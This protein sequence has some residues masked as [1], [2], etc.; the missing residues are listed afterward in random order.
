MEKTKQATK[1]KRS[2][3]SKLLRIFAWLVASVFFLAILILI[4]IQ[5]PAVQNFGRKKVVA[6]LEHKL[7]TKVEIGKL[8]INFPT[9]L[10]LQNVYFEDQSKDTLLYGGEIKVNLKMLRL[11][12]NDIEIEEISLNNILAKIKRLPPDSVFNF[13]FIA[14]AFAGDQKKETKMKDTAAL[15]MN[16]D[17]LLVNHTRIIYKDAFTGNDMDL[18]FGHL[19]TRI[20]TFDPAHLLFNFPFI[21]LKGLKGHFYQLAPLQKPIENAIAEASAQPD[22]Y[23]QL[24]NKE[25]KLSDVDVIYKSE[26]THL[27][28]SFVI[29][30]LIL[31]PKTIDLKNSIITL[32]D[33]T[34]T[35]SD[36][37]IEMASQKKFLQTKK[38]M[39]KD[40][41]LTV[42]PTPPF[43]IIAEEITI[44][45]SRLRYDDPSVPHTP[46]GMDY[47]HLDLQELSLNAINLQ[48]SM[49]TILASVKSASLKEKSG[50]VLNN[51]STDFA[52]NPTGVSLQNLLIET[53]G[54]EIKNAASITYP[55]LEAIVKDPGLIGLDIDLQN[56]KIT[57]KDLLTFVPQM[58][59]QSSSLSPHSTLYIN[60]RIT[61]KVNDM[62]FQRLI[63]RG[64]SATD[65]NATG[66]IK[67]L[68]DP[69]RLY[70]DV[71]IQKFQTSKKD[72][73]SFLP[74]NMVPPNITLPES[75]ATSGK[76]KGG[77]NKLY[78]DLV[79]T[80]SLG[81]AKIKGT[82]INITDQN[83]A[84]YDLVVHAG[85]LQLGTIMQNPKL[86]FL[87]GDIKVKGSGFKPETANATFSGVIAN[88]TLNN[89][90]YRNIKAGGSIA[91]KIYKIDASV[92]DPNLDA[93]IAANGE[94]A[95]KFPGVHL[96]ATIDSI[97]TLP[98][99]LTASEIKYHGQIEGDFTNTDPDNLAGNLLVTHSVLVNNGKRIALDSLE[100]TAANMDGGHSLTLQSDLLSATIK[101]QY[102]LTQLADVF[103]Q[104]IDPYFSLSNKINSTKI[105]PYHF[106]IN[107]GTFDNAALKAFLPELKQLKPVSLTGNFASDSGWNVSIKSPY[108]LYGSYT[109][110]AAN[111]T[112]GTHKGILSY[113]TSFKQFKSGTSLSVYATSLEGT[114]Q[115]NNL[116]FT[117]H[118]KDQKSVTK[119]SLSGLLSQPKTGNYQFSLLPDNLLL[120]YDK[121]S[122]NTDNA[123]QYF[124]KDIAAHNFIL[125]EGTQQLSLNSTSSGHNS[126]L[127]IDFKNFKIATLSS[128]V[129][130][131]SLMVN[132]LL[133]G[134]AVVKNIQTQPTFTTDLTV[135]D[136]SIYKDT[137]GTLT[138]KV[139]NELANTYHAAISLAGRGNEVNVNGDYL[140]T[141]TNSSYDFVLDVGKF[142]MK[143]LEGFSR[144]SIRDARGFLFGK[145]AVNGTLK[146]PNIDG[147]I[148]FDNTSFIA[149]ALN[150]VFKVDKEAIAVISNK[151]IELNTFTIRDTA[152]NALVIDG[153]VNTTNFYNY[154]SRIIFD[155]KGNLFWH[156][157]DLGLLKIICNPTYLSF[158]CKTNI[159]LHRYCSQ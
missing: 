63:V 70:A 61:G 20:T 59:L 120:N 48:Y 153:S 72:L 105:A 79:I 24:F 134:N 45:K 88:V 38:G 49:D 92:H 27:N 19:D 124:N 75:L 23:L 6:F 116:N 21:T 76:F 17:R 15:K 7:K 34:L 146:E 110:D 132:G 83:K 117:L 57:V 36:I 108:L 133:N 37:I 129:Q 66:I 113:S 148:H 41:V 78:T 54:S 12:K 1:K 126:P 81:E 39:P 13:Q 118:I 102:K 101:G 99:H 154:S 140:V 86:G 8:D 111:F 104:S 125:S 32:N 114:L 85:N 122:I 141:P 127:Q 136:L 135:A 98:L 95:G 26:P 151:G 11:L 73:L 112:A 87:T 123:I 142:Q 62:N 100:V 44:N 144:G 121:W 156:F 35:N 145:I 128:F 40:T 29:S 77:M 31:H 158:Q 74:K 91:H 68:P 131:D 46:K 5:I 93:V 84:R 56:S 115:N 28:S 119:Y 47:S 90:N 94:F 25:M 159:H 71:N 107:A 157:I 109:I 51:L 55:S 33:A 149:S 139:N 3:L 53:P 82:L 9:T 155:K 18:T 65:I 80:T 143:S 10:S 138:A 64:L 69:K 150:N 22:N 67:G 106:S 60:A 130:D 152:N 96:K 14:D 16:I 52:M 4:L 137:L 2:I 103:Q 43:K 58:S 97:K 89:Y 30:D 147:T 42:A 50:F